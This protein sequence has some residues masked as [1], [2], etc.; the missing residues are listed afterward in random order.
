MGI[1]NKV[2]VNESN[3]QPN[4]DNLNYI[5]QLLKNKLTKWFTPRVVPKIQQCGAS[6]RRSRFKLS[7]VSPK[8]GDVSPETSRRR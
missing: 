5:R 3:K 8:V 6:P 7:D 4:Q 2:M 1:V